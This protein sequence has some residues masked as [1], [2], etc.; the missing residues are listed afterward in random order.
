MRAYIIKNTERNNLNIKANPFILRRL[1]LIS[2]I[3]VLIMNSSAP[4]GFAS[5]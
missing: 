4:I 3:K 2:P 1:F 5:C